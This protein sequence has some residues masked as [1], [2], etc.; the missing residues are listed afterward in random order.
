MTSILFINTVTTYIFILLISGETQVALF[1]RE[2]D[3]FS[4]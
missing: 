2:M 4:C 1:S 3:Y